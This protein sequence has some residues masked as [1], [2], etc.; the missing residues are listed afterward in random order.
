M[1][2]PLVSIIV[3]CYNAEKYIFETLESLI[4][5]TYQNIEIIVVNDGSTDKSE[6]IIRNVSDERIKYFKQTN[7]GQCAAL[8][9]GFKFSQGKYIK[10]Y[11]ADDVLNPT[12][13]E[14]QVEVLE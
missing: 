1:S 11:D 12:A 10:F 4:N 6:E 2:H 7:K 9:T 8:N 3:S 13:I 5:Q 14:G